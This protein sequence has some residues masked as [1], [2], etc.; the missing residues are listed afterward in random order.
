M[1]G[2]LITLECTPLLY[3]QAIRIL[4]APS[5]L[6]N[7]WYQMMLEESPGSTGQGAR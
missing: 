2:M 1:P 3:K 5:Q 4:Y 6:D 7:R